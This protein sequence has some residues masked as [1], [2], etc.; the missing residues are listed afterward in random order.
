MRNSQTE[1]YSQGWKP[2]LLSKDSFPSRAEARGRSGTAPRQW[3]TGLPTTTPQAE[4]AD[5]R[6]DS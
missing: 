3:Q 4:T 5:D 6:N 1:P 2:P